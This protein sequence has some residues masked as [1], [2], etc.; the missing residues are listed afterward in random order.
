MTNKGFIRDL[1]LKHLSGDINM[2]VWSIFQ[3]VNSE[4]IF[5]IRGKYNTLFF[6]VQYKSLL[7]KVKLC[8]NI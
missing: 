6:K 2:P 8:Y 1:F 5:V 7:V 4:N 3:V